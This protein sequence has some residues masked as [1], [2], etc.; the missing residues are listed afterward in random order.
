M[1]RR[2]LKALGTAAFTLLT[3]LGLTA[4]SSSA[5]G[6]EISIYA[7]YPSW[8][9]WGL[10]ATFVL[11]TVVVLHSKDVVHRRRYLALGTGIML[12]ANAFLLLMPVVRG[13]AVFGGGDMF[14][15]L[16]RVI[17]ILETGHLNE[18][19]YYPGIHLHAV[20]LMEVT[21]LDYYT[22]KNVLAP[23]FSVAYWLGILAL[24]VRV[25]DNSTAFHYFVPFAL[26]P[27]LKRSEVYFGPNVL[28]F[29]LYPLLLYALFSVRRSRNRFV[30]LVALVFCYFIFTHPVTTLIGLGTI[31]LV[32]ASRLVTARLRGHR[33]PIKR[34]VTV[35]TI[36]VAV[37]VVFVS[38]YYSFLKILTMTVSMLGSLVLG[39][40]TSQL[41]EYSNALQN[42]PLSLADL[43]AVVVFRK[44]TEIL[45]TVGTVFVILYL[46][47]HVKYRDLELRWQYLFW[48]A[49]FGLFCALAAALL[50]KPIMLTWT[51]V[52]KFAE[53][54]AVLLVAT[55]AYVYA[56]RSRR[57]VGRRDVVVVGVVLV[58]VTL[59]VFGTY[60]S[61]LQRETNSHVPE[62]R[63]EGMEWYLDNRDADRLAFGFNYRYE[64]AFE[65]V[66]PNPRAYAERPIPAHFGYDEN[67]TFATRNRVGS[68]LLVTQ[69][70]EEYYPALHPEYPEYWQFTPRDFRR[71]DRDERLGK[72]Y[73]NGGLRIYLASSEPP[74]RPGG[75]NATA[76][77]A[78]RVG[79]IRGGPRWSGG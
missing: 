36:P 60:N 26:L 59:I 31:A 37:G 69:R 48:V 39:I 9:W 1:G 23:V 62:T 47:Y 29:S 28:S 20:M 5:K 55:A 77:P 4:A 25:T 45:L 6:Y 10:V 75:Q 43:L 66:S 73:A 65:G 38:W 17:E 52:L 33:L 12:V 46:A 27:I 71:L 44:G 41:G 42:V 53:F 14:T 61:P 16:G 15:H 11:G 22:I 54:F 49:G 74:G 21:G 56:G 13:Y 79:P 3:V 32:A 57:T 51:R 2:T 35:V 19:N 8:F 18:G 30:T 78:T 40:G 58:F 67:A 72:I 76:A 64:H 68:Y 63:I 24:A 50:V 34:S 70:L 7:A